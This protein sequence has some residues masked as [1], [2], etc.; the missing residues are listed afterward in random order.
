MVGPVL[1]RDHAAHPA[2]NGCVTTVWFMWGGIKDIRALFRALEARKRD[3]L[4]NGMVEGHV[5]LA[6]RVAFAA[7]DASHRQ[8]GHVSPADKA[9]DEEIG[10]PQ[11]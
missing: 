5:S 4:D 3:D 7:R 2:L 9:A 1:P 10:Q 6:D 8:L 11:E